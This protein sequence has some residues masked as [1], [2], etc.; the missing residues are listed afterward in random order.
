MFLGERGRIQTEHPPC[1]RSHGDTRTFQIQQTCWL[2]T[3]EMIPGK[4]DVAPSSSVPFKT[5]NMCNARPRRTWNRGQ[6]MT[7]VDRDVSKGVCINADSIM[8]ELSRYPLPSVILRLER[9]LLH[10]AARPGGV[11]SNPCG[12]GTTY[13]VITWAGWYTSRHSK[14]YQKQTIV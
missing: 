4:C 2:P 13:S 12:C 9:S 1:Y 6:V 8:N 10:N 5:S 14:H 3:T 7:I 11:C